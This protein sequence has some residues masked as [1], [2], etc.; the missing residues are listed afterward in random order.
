[1]LAA[2]AL[3]A[4]I[5]ILAATAIQA[6]TPI[7]EPFFEQY[8][9]VPGTVQRFEFIAMSDDGRF[10]CYHETGSGM[11]VGL[12]DRDTNTWSLI[13]GLETPVDVRSISGDGS[14]LVGSKSVPAPTRGGS[15]TSVAAKWDTATG[16]ATILDTLP[17]GI[18]FSSANACAFDG[19]TIV[20]SQT[21]DTGTEAFVWTQSTG[22]VGIGDLEGGLFQS[23]AADVSDDGSV[24]VGRGRD[25]EGIKAFRW[26]SKDGM[27][28]L[29]DFPGGSNRSLAVTVSGDGMVIGGSSAGF[30]D[31]TEPF[32]WTEATGLQ[33]I[34]PLNLNGQDFFE[35][36][37]T[38]L[39]FDGS[40]AGGRAGGAIGCYW[41]AETGLVSIN[42]FVENDL[43]QSTNPIVNLGFVRSMSADGSVM[44]GVGFT[45]TLS[46]V[47]W[48]FGMCPAT[49]PADLDGDGCVGSPDLAFLL[50][51]WG[52]S[53]AT[54]I[55]DSG[56][57]GASDLA[58]IL[59]A[60]TGC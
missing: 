17:A 41:T 26:T 14:T 22:L 19:S 52:A 51:G 38:A 44:I 45:P 47:N 20:G 32:I 24:V 36:Q 27:T 2:T 8:E 58:V 23:I 3:N 54:D 37:I 30:E 59:A 12:W 57:T 50:A 39:N 28:N 29:G 33:P 21:G 9:I 53:G 6:G 5:P 18:D 49:D 1:M 60:W 35:G 11:P 34:A 7:C 15:V 46:E 55:D 40:I 13:A 10:V 4:V 56:S 31:S 16:A 48:I 42:D 43:G 25:A